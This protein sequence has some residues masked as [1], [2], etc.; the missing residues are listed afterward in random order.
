[1]EAHVTLNSDNPCG[2]GGS[3]QIAL[4]TVSPFELQGLEGSCILETQA[5][6]SLPKQC[7]LVMSPFRVVRF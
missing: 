5:T 1:M 6:E 3:L 2:G 4:F 7:L